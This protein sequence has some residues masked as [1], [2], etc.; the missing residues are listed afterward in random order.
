MSVV[1]QGLEDFSTACLDDVIIWSQNEEQHQMHIQQ[2][3]NRLREHGLKLKL[4]KCSFYQN[5]TKYLGF[6]ISDKGIQPDP[7]KVKVIKALPQP[8]T[9]RDVRSFIGMT[10]Y[11]RRFIPRYSE[12]A[13][14][15]TA[16]TR[17]YVRF[18]WTDRC[19]EKL[20]AYLITVPLLAYPDHQ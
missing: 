19:S 2:V 5:R 12:I 16:L 15:L 17:K 6:I 4:K 18:K 3:F 10:G 13:E 9:I 14:P 8:Q 20:K 11:Y 7:E 1:L